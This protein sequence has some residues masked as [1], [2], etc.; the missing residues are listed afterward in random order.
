MT[1]EG[2]NIMTPLKGEFLIAMP[3]LNDPN[4]SRTVVCICEF[5]SEGALGMIVNRLYAAFCARDLFKELS[6]EYIKEAESLPIYNGGPVNIGDVFILHGAPFHWAGCH[7]IN[8]WLALTN[9]RDVL[10]AIGRGEGPDSFLIILGCSG[11]GGGQLEME[12]KNNFWLTAPADEAVLFDTPVE[13]RW[14]A[15]MALIN[16]DPA[17][18]SGTA[19]NA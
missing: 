15:G 11:W 8:S 19:G 3:A 7:R 16:I 12:L 10:E 5:S 1:G 4:F 13:D 9:T 6:I 17:F 18:L 14:T 2:R